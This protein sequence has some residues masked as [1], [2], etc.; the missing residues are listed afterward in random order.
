MRENGEMTSPELEMPPPTAG[1]QTL[2]R[3]LRALEILA[4]APS[5]MS[6]TNLAKQLGVHRSSAYRVLRTLEDHRFVLRDESG[7]IRL[8]PKLAAI[9]RN[10]S[11]PLQQSALKE[12]NGLSN[13][14]G[15]TTFL[16]VLDD[17]EVI[18]IL[19]VEPTYGHG[20]VAQR[21]GARHPI[22]LG[23]PGH[24]I[25]SSLSDDEHA[26]TFFG[27]KLSEP[28]SLARE[29]GYALSH[30]EVI[31]GLTSVAVPVRSLGEPAAALAIVNIGLPEDLDGLVAGLKDA[32]RRIERS[33]L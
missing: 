13:S 15:V 26:K 1:S 5:A 28:A 7:M 25:E 31:P 2:D 21:P 16:A 30:D 32:A 20:A 18:T 8:G 4:E 11:A 24:A 3:G 29:R 10:A 22:S 9:A 6:I 23:A 27:A 17:S 19:S 33:A 12:L 14:F